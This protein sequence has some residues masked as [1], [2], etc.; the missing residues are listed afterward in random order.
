MIKNK[1]SKSSRN[2]FEQRIGKIKAALTVPRGPPHIAGCP[3]R[4]HGLDKLQIN[5][6]LNLF[7]RN[8]F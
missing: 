4:I 1:K 8:L 5:L 3:K 7:Y 6:V 2:Y